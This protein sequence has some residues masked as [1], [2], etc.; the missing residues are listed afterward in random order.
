MKARM[1]LLATM[2]LM[3]A[4]AATGFAQTEETAV[5]TYPI[6][7]QLRD[8]SGA[9]SQAQMKGNA[10]VKANLTAE[11][12]ALIAQNRT[13]SEEF[14]TAFKATLTEEQLA[15]VSNMELTR[16]EKQAALQATFTDE[17]REMYDAH[18]ALVADQRQQ[19]KGTLSAQQA[20]QAKQNGM[21][22]AGGNK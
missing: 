22:R 10:A 7:A 5:D 9:G 16:E 4:V 14:R 20:G 17:Q 18:Q 2:I 8:G 6:K 19:L 21:K 1:N 11:Q 3:V 12:Q 15:I 13:N